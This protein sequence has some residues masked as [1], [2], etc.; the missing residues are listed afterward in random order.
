MGGGNEQTSRIL[1]DQFPIVPI[2]G[3]RNDVHF[4][5]HRG[6]PLVLL[7]NSPC[8]ES[9]TSRDGGPISGGALALP[10]PLGRQISA[11]RPL[12]VGVTLVVGEPILVAAVPLVVLGLCF[13]FRPA[14]L[15]TDGTKR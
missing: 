4:S 10:A 3:S 2:A 5:R 7:S 15:T 12:V 1:I 6:P 8:G 13:G 11:A 9:K 14:P